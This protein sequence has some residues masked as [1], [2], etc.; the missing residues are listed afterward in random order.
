M[1]GIQSPILISHKSASSERAFAEL[2]THEDETKKTN[3][4][5]KLL[6]NYSENS[7][8]EY[9]SKISAPPIIKNF[10]IIAAHLI[11]LVGIS[12]L[13]KKF[14]LPKYLN[15]LLGLSSMYLGI[16]GDKKLNELPKIGAL[17]VASAA[18]CDL[19]KM[20]NFLRRSLIALVLT[21]GQEFK[22]EE[23]SQKNIFESISKKILSK[24][25]QTEFKVNTAIPV[26]EFL[27]DR[28]DNKFLAF[29]SK[30]LSMSGIIA[31][32][33]EMFNKLGIN[34]DNDLTAI[35]TSSGCPMCGGAVIGECISTEI[36]PIASMQ[37]QFHHS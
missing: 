4:I 7:P 25:M 20:P 5:L 36:A 10:L 6:H 18:I 1:L 16:W 30:I 12:S 8:G 15:S 34:K 32:S 24:I 11:P 26:A 2:T 13:A 9:I 21:I 22:L 23:F 3:S 37:N 19:T 35:A 17:T 33:S 28:I 14:G 29:L 27:A 31:S